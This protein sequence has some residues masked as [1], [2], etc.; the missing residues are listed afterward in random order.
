MWIERIEIDEGDIEHVTKH[1]VTIAEIE[2]VF[3]SR[4][5]IRRN[6]GGRT[7]DYCAVALASE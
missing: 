1:E 2:A 3:T 5:T 7:G 6:K 4:P